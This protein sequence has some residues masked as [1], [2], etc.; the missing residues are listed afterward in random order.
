MSLYRIFE[1]LDWQELRER[2]ETSN[3]RRAHFNLHSSYEEAVQKTLICLLNGTYI[4]PHYHRHSH[5]KELFVV[6]HGLVKVVFF[7]QVGLI[8]DV[9]YLGD[10]VKS[11][12]I[13]VFPQSIHT[14]VCLSE[15]ARVMEVKQGPFVEDDCKEFLDWT[16][17]E[18]S[19]LSDGYANWLK[20]AE[21]GDIFGI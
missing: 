16:V 10:D 4:P 19:Q 17:P 12:M 1:Q 3:R 5:Q 9:I 14:V 21:V 20:N 6:L 7:N 11:F 13:E 15:H 2:A 18:F 8:T